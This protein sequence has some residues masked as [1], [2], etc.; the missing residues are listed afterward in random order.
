MKP[1]KIVQ[2]VRTG[3]SDLVALTEDGEMFERTKDN[4]DMSPRPRFLWKK[5]LGPFD[6]PPPIQ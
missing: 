1:P 6:E 3:H 5:I 2:L 4:R